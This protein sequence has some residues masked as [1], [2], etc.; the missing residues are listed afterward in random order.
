MAEGCATCDRCGRTIP[1]PPGYGT[2][3]L[4]EF[5]YCADRAAC[6]AEVQFQK[7]QR[8]AKE[9]RWRE[10]FKEGDVIAFGN[11]DRPSWT[12]GK[13]RVKRVTAD[14]IELTPLKD[15]ETVDEARNSAN[16][17]YRIT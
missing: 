7:E 8:A 14:G 4:C 13:W 12:D 3:Y 11:K 17:Q 6:D 5:F 2:E 10:N 15:D 16:Q 1:L 9:A